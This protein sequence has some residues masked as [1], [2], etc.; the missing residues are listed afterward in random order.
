[1]VPA[2]E[3]SIKSAQALSR[4]FPRLCHLRIGDS[5]EVVIRVL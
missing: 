2:E 4:Q 1:M 5:T 3:R